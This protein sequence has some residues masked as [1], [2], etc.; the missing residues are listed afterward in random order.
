MANELKNLIDHNFMGYASY[1]I[2]ERA[3]PDI[4]D[5]LKPV[6]R[7]ILHTLYEVDDNRFHKVANIVGH[8]MRYHPHGDASIADALINMAQKNFFIDQQGNFGNVLTGDP[9]SAPR[10]IECKLSNLAKDNLFNKE[11][12]E[13]V[14]SYD[15][16]NREP[17]I[18]PAKIPVLL[19]CGAEGIAVGLST[20]VL[21]H[22]F[23]ELLECQIKI[24]KGEDFEIYP[25]FIQ[26]GSMDV[27]DY[28]AGKGKIRVRAKVEVLDN[29]TLLIREIPYGTTTE[30][31]IA[32]VENAIHRGKLKISSI[33][34]FTTEKIE[35]EL[36]I[37]HGST[38]ENILP[39]LFLYTDCENSISSNITV[40]KD[41]FPIETDVKEILHHNT[42]KLISNLQKEL[43]ANLDKLKEKLHEKILT[44]I[45]IQ[46]KIY[47]L[48][49]EIDDFK[50]IEKTIFNSFEPY[51]EELI[52]KLTNHDV[53]K[54]LSIPIKKISKFD[55]NKTKEEIE[56][57]N[58]EI[59][60]IN[61]NLNNINKYT[62]KYLDS[63]ITKYKDSNPRRTTIEKFENIDITK[64]AVLDLKVGFDKKTSYLGSEIK[65]EDFVQCSSFDKILILFKNGEYKVINIPDKMFLDSKVL[66]FMR[67][68]EL[69]TIHVI[70]S[71]NST[72]LHYMKKFVINKFI[73]DKVYRFIPEDSK[74]VY[75]SV[76][77]NPVV[78]VDYSYQKRAKISTEYLHLGRLLTK[79]VT[80]MGN[81]VSTKPISKI[82]TA[83]KA[84]ANLFN[85][86]PP[87][88]VK[89]KPIQEEKEEPT[90]FDLNEE[91]ET[92]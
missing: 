36:K 13:Y 5:G 40:I 59:D 89:L 31:I 91:K 18:L 46:N 11:I 28:Q 2:K 57:I 29:K 67:Q 14:D 9:A 55:F 88:M 68:G 72:G 45:F 24:I 37:G 19:M 7:R 17:V 69:K 92:T 39:R 60:K 8:T 6:Q 64:V 48:L 66:K 1:V 15:G 16:R 30:S 56:D 35:I 82:S 84:I 41:G 49:E 71:E 20:K 62:I 86:T 78:Q 34:D 65:S 76:E 87:E 50:E 22:N 70:Y 53:D 81:Q 25:D 27:S 4:D 10:Y 75:F 79:S 26:G 21:P 38:A 44:K 3:I 80:A 23:I 43:K 85:D 12:T 61:N 63:L 42:N 54:L 33:N 77:E 83:T 58:K 52:A 74:L 51:K 90:I 32:S 73:L 47:S